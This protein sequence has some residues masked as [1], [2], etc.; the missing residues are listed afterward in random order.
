MASAS[1]GHRYFLKRAY[2]EIHPTRP[3]SRSSFR[4]HAVAAFRWIFPKRQ[5]IVAMANICDVLLAHESTPR[6]SFGMD[7]SP[8]PATHP[9]QFIGE[10]HD[11]S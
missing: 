2:A 10:S 1:P 6:I 11:R 8:A 3:C 4:H 5:D 9:K 7:G